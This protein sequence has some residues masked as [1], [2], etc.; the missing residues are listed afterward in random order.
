MSL[1]FLEKPIEFTSQ[2]RNKAVIEKEDAKFDMRLTKAIPLE[3]VVWYKDDQPLDFENEKI[4]EQYSVKADGEL[5]SLYIKRCGYDSAG[6]Y[7]V[8]VPKADIE[9]KAT[10]TVN[11]NKLYDMNL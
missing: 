1:F 9:S 10:L 5:Y 8:R 7:S 6:E 4:K 2:L 3:E 11:G